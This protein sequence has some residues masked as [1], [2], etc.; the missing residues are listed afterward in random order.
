MNPKIADIA[1]R[2]ESEPGEHDEDHSK[3][4]KD[5]TLK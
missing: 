2:R 3:P 1:R 5:K 4:Q